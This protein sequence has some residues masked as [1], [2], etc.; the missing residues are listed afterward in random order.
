MLHDYTIQTQ[1]VP[2]A[3]WQPDQV[4]DGD[5]GVMMGTLMVMRVHQHCVL[6]GAGPA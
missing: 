2:K 3:S 5:K 4:D 1:W 6:A